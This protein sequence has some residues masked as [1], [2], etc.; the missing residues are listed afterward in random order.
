MQRLTLFGLA[1]AALTLSPAAHAQDDGARDEK[2]GQE[3]KAE[4]EEKPDYGLL[5][6]RKPNEEKWCKQSYEGET[7]WGC[8]RSISPSLGVSAIGELRNANSDN[9]IE[10]LFTVGGSFSIMNWQRDGILSTKLIAHGTYMTQGGGR[11]YDVGLAGFVGARWKWGG[12]IAIGAEIWNN[13]YSLKSTTLDRT[14]GIDIPIFLELGPEF[15]HLVGGFA[16]SYVFNPHRRVD[17]DTDY[18]VRG[19]GH[20]LSWWAGVE[21][22]IRLF[23]LAI[24]YQRHWMADGVMNHGVT[25]GLGF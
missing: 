15:F 24:A 22:Q 5:F 2:L 14:T 11:A 21:T 7:P 17:W 23:T 25:L 18:W 10:L 1:L 20:E 4:K 16:P 3:E 19:F 9:P 8:T 6:N 12:G 13:A